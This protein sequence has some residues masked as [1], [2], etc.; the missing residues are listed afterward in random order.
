VS[1]R[2]LRSALSAE[3]SPGTVE[4][5]P[6][7]PGPLVLELLGAVISG[8]APPQ[9][10]LTCVGAV[11]DA[12]GDPRG[13]DLLRAAGTLAR[14]G[15]RPARIQPGP[16]GGEPTGARAH[17]R[18]GRRLLARARPEP[19]GGAP[20][21]L[22]GEPNEGSDAQTMTTMTSVAEVM[23]LAARSG[24]PPTALLRR[25]AEQER[26]RQADAQ[27]KA[28]RR[29][30]VLLVI[31]AGICLLPAFVLLGIVPLVIRLISG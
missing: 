14:S 27:L 1:H 2:R 5:S 24:V 26:R 17:G 18:S 6:S 4:P 12:G 29:L 31:P 22:G 15:A 11:L 10:A 19:V 9:S 25:A 21:S 8:G 16:I 13:R 23:T 30:E 7:M 28:V 3:A 20:P